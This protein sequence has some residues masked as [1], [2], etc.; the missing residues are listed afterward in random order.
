MSAQEL[1]TII[2]LL[3]AKPPPEDP[4]IG[5]QRARFRKLIEYITDSR[6]VAHEPVDA[7]GVPAAWFAAGDSEPKGSVLYLHGGGYCLGSID[8]HAPLCE[9]IAAASGARVLLLDYRLAPE[10][11]FPA[12]IDDAVA[13]YRWLLSQGH[14]P[15]TIA[16]AGDSAGGGLTPAVLCAIR[17][18]RVALPACGVCI[19]PWTDL[20]CTSE[21]M[22]RYEARDPMVKREPL[23]QMAALYLGD[24][25]PANPLASPLHADLAGLPPLLIQ[26]ASEE[27]LLDDATG[28][29][30]RAEAAGG[31]VTLRQW[32]DMLHVWHLFAPMLSEGRD[33]IAE[34][35]AYI[36]AQ[37]S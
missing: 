31:S 6:A 25:D 28:L 29:A 3:T 11:P 35:G 22:E 32:D 24:A 18:A 16:I 5:Y 13:A 2:D 9:G 26:V 14:G 8:T 7:G 27:S 17:D 15:E 33:G 34:V 37:L 12:A 19:S 21:S 1:K 23:R 10:H 36:K 30:A 20:A 4:P